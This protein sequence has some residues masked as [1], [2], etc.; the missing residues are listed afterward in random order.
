MLPR[1]LLLLF[2]VFCVAGFSVKATEADDILGIWYTDNNESKVEIFKCGEG[3]CGKI[4]WLEEPNYAADDEMAG[5]PKID[6][7]NPDESKQDQPIIG[8]E[9]M[10]G[11]AFDGEQWVEGQIYDPEKGK[12]YSCYMEMK[13]GGKRLKVRG[14]V[15]VSLLGRTTY[16]KREP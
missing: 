5:K 13:S 10:S 2:T 7:E 16:W 6:R 3:Y 9:I 11:F 1:F 14:F 15:G 12:T 8:L 4:I